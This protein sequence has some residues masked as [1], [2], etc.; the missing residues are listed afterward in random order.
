[1]SRSDKVAGGVG[2]LVITV[3][4]GGEDEEREHSALFIDRSVMCLTVTWL[5]R[6]KLAKK[7]LC[8][9]CERAPNKILE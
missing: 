2:E 8:W 3:V 9:G 5:D 1:M 6:T 4:G 7:A